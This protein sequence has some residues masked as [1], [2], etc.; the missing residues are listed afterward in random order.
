ME[1]L[2]DVEKEKGEKAARATDCDGEKAKDREIAVAMWIMF[3]TLLG[4]VVAARLFAVLMGP[5]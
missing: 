4:M 3:L 1:G 5:C 2:L